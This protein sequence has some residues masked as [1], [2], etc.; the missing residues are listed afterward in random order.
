MKNQEIYEEELY[1]YQFGNIDKALQWLFLLLI[2]LLPL[3]IRAKVIEFAAPDFISSIANTGLKADVFNYY[4]WVFL[5]VLSTI[6]LLLF[7]IKI[8]KGYKINK[9]MINLPLLILASFILF[10]GMFA[11]YKGI[12]M[13]GMYNRYEGTLTYLYYLTIFFV[14]ANTKYDKQFLHRLSLALGLGVVVNGLLGISHFFGFNEVSNT[15]A[16]TIVLPAAMTNAGSGEIW[17]TFSHPN[18][19]SGFAAIASVYFLYLSGISAT[20]RDK[21]KYGVLA[22]ISFLLIISSLSS[23]GFLTFIVLLPAIIILTVY[24]SGEKVKSIL[25]IA[26]ILAFCSIFLII[27]SNFNDQV[28]E[29]IIN[30]FKGI[31]LSATIKNAEASERLI[32]ETTFEEFNLP[33]PGWSSGTGRTYIWGKTLDLIMEKPIL[34]YGL[35]T[36]TYYFPQ[37]DKYKVSNI[38]RYET[39]VDKPHNIYLAIAFGSGVVSLMAFL[40]IIMFYL[41]KT[42]TSIK[43]KRCEITYTPAIFLAIV[44][45]LVQGM[46]NDSIIGMSVIFWLFMGIGISI[47]NNKKVISN[48]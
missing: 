31:P 28:S 18:Y 10:S 27:M 12:A 47:L 5:G 24:F 26:S 37:N 42:L 30:I 45:F 34:G 14:A 23:S 3:I 11:E 35:D 15:V 4:K 44:A 41:L 13:K 19:L 1:K 46:F 22:F 21:I 16:K 6:I 39:L 38:W 29:E 9:S 20:N 33:Q 48:V 7:L 36:L 40:T 17:C 2:G 8:F 43:E 25:V 32:E